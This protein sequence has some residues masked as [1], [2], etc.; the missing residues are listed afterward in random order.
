MVIQPVIQLITMASVRHL[1]EIL[2]LWVDF[3]GKAGG[4]QGAPS[5]HIA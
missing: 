4:V 2:C 5:H 3:V 1:V